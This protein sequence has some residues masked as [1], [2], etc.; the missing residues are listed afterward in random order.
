M[1][2]ESNNDS[3]ALG[4]ALP[5]HLLKKASNV[6]EKRSEEASS[7]EDDKKSLDVQV[8]GPVLPSTS[9]SDVKELKT[10]QKDADKSSTNEMATPVLPTEA[11][12]NLENPGPRRLHWSNFAS[13]FTREAP[14]SCRRGC[15]CC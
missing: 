10:T 12:V 3:V 11:N 6:S 13:S 15:S 2:V 8:L 1:S 14:A 4:P 9:N 5:P 7:K